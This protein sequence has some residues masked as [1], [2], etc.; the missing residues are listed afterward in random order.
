LSFIR[1]STQ[2]LLNDPDDD[3]LVNHPAMENKIS[4][5][6]AYKTNIVTSAKN[7]KINNAANLKITMPACIIINEMEP[8]NVFV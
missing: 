3:R 6:T 7:A 4:K 8:A 1:R 2:N 5:R